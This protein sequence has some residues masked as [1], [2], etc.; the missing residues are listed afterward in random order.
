[1]SQGL[2]ISVARQPSGILMGL[3]GYLDCRGEG[4]LFAAWSQAGGPS[5]RSLR[6]DVNGIRPMDNGGLSALVKVA[7]AVRSVGASVSMAVLALPCAG[8]LYLLGFHSAR[9]RGS[10]HVRILRGQGGAA[11]WSWLLGL[12][13]GNPSGA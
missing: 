7:A 1:M 8:G 5:A 2:D 13:R 10:W 4:A 11:R 12:S 3:A 6:L 9:G